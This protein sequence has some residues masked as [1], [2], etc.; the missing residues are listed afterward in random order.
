[1]HATI[2]DLDGDGTA[3]WTDKVMLERLISRCEADAMEAFRP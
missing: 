3:S 1:V 2:V